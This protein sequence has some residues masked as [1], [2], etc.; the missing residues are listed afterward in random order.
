LLTA[1]QITAIAPDAASLKAGRD[2]DSPRK[3]QSLGG[4]DLALWGLAQGSGNDPYQTRISLADL[5]TK[6]SCPSRKFPCKHALGLMLVS[7]NKPSALTQ[8]ERPPWVTEWLDARAAREEK[9]TA[10]AADKSSA[11]TDEKAAAKR[12]EKRDSRVSDGIALLQQSLLDLTRDGLASPA[13]RDSS[14][15]KNLARRMIDCQAPG[16]AGTLRHIADTIL[17]SPDADTELPHK[18]GHLYLLLHTIS[19][20]PQD[21]AL[22]AEILARIGGKITDPDLPPPES[23]EDDWFV[24]GRRVEERD[25]LLTSSTWMLGTRSGRWARILRFAPV[26]QTIIEPWPLGANVHTSLSFAPGLLPM[27]SAATPDGITRWADVPPPTEDVWENLLDRF[28][29][30]LTA[31]P[32]LRA[33]PFLLQL[34]PADASHL[35]DA[36]GNSLP[37][38]AAAGQHLLVDAI[39][40]GTP[41]L[42]CGEW[43]G[44]SIRLLAILDGAVWFPLTP[45]LACPPTL[46]SPPPCS[47]RH[48]HRSCRPRRIPP[49]MPNGR[50]FL[51]KTRPRPSSTPLPSPA[52]STA[53]AQK[54]SPP[55]NPSLHPARPKPAPHW[56]RPPSMPPADYSPGNP[57][58]SCPN[59]S[60]TPP[61]LAK[62][63]PPAS[64]PSF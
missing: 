26:P 37:W 10:R 33:L 15:W 12:R 42:M 28:A 45:Q 43:D 35:S 21:P 47:A 56:P 18:L 54:P 60:T 1:D 39:C 41:T 59:G 23:I 19:S 25:R 46:S 51:R 11:P 61:P 4:D 32:F 38:L 8:T 36:A 40:G 48:G 13:A 30:A 2:L 34:T 24:A 16:L 20:A 49:S 6:C 7:L 57:R 14:T 64:S 29:A 52:H 17:L 22:R 50:P 53:P 5:A 62:S 58:N 9:S 3:W 55:R 31:N 27:R 44:R 63:F